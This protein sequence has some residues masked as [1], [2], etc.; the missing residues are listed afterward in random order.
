MI[1]LE[2]SHQTLSVYIQFLFKNRF[3]FNKKGIISSEKMR[4]PGN[5]NYNYAHSFFGK[6][7][8]S[9]PLYWLVHMFNIE[10]VK[11]NK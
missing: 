9:K 6:D 11:P 8:Q 4:N 7:F 10:F 5:Y 2:K 1:A 3:G